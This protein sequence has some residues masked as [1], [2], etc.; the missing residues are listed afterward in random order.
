MRQSKTL[1]IC[2]NHLG[3]FSLLFLSFFFCDFFRVLNILCLCFCSAAG[4][5]SAGARRE[6]EVVCV[7]RNG[8]RWW[9][10]EGWVVLYSFCIC[11]KWVIISIC[12]VDNF[13]SSL[14]GNILCHFMGY[15][16]VIMFEWFLCCKCCMVD[17]ICYHVCLLAW[18]I[19]VGSE[20]WMHERNF[21]FKKKNLVSM[22]T[23]LF[24][25]PC[26]FDCIIDI[27]VI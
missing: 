14:I 26:L 4:Y 5:V 10:I 3:L 20:L 22:W 27:G 16:T 8:F 18:L 17:S 2:A 6:W 12:F 11:W 9:W 15:L 25:N 7:A 13:L 21:D 1:K 24:D 19:V 23:I